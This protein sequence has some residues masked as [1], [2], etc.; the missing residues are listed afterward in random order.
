MVITVENAEKWLAKWCGLPSLMVPNGLPSSRYFGP[1]QP[2]RLVLVDPTDGHLKSVGASSPILIRT[3]AYPSSLHP[4]ALSVLITTHSIPLLL[5]VLLF[6]R[7]LS[8][9][10]WRKES[11]RRSY[12]LEPNPTVTRGA[13][14][15]K[16]S[17]RDEKRYIDKTKKDQHAAL[18]C[19][20]L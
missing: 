7:P 20:I 14:R 1:A 12:L 10:S 16:E 8:P 11:R 18:D 19:Y 2:L 9:P 17:T 4:P 13:H 6:L 5:A 3:T 15:E